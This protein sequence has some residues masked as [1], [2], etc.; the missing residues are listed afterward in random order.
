MRLIDSGKGKQNQLRIFELFLAQA[1]Q[2]EQELWG[3]R[4]DQVPEKYAADEEMYNKF[5]AFLVKENG[6][7]IEAPHPRAGKPLMI[8]SALGLV[9]QLIVTLR[10]SE[11]CGYVRP[12]YVLACARR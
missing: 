7:V 10:D 2:H 6:Y 3:L 4:W 8:G 12:A 9:C 5:G 1:T 11:W